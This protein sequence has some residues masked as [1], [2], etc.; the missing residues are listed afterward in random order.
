[1]QA[2]IIWLQKTQTVND[3]TF[4]SFAIHNKERRTLI[5]TS[6][7]AD[8]NSEPTALVDKGILAVVLVLQGVVDAAIHL[9]RL[10]LP[11]IGLGGPN[12]NRKSHRVD[13]QANPTASTDRGSLAAVLSF[14]TVLGTVIGL[15]GFVVQF[16]RLRGIHFSA[17]I[18][19]LIAVVI[20]TCLRAWVRRGLATPPQYT[21]LPSGFKLKWLATA[22]GDPKSA[23]RLNILNSENEGKEGKNASHRSQK[24]ETLD[25]ESKG[26]D[27]KPSD[28]S[29]SES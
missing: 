15:C 2:R 10:L 27:P 13:N 3:Q 18:A 21:P 28:S 24:C 26:R 8:K 16:V 14:K 7:R 29:E 20:M 22:L 1:M 19:Q 25:L 9:W 17:S 5:T 6:R 4:K 12:V 11:F 23:P